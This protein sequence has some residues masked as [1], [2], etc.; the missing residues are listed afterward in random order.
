M[1]EIIIGFLN[2]N[3]HFAV[4]FTLIS[5]SRT[6]FKPA[7]SLIQLYV[8]ATPT[9]K[10]NEVWNKIKEKKSFKAAA[11]AIDYFLSIKLP[12]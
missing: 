4:L 10:D 1:T 6:V 12:K 3:P 2:T 8:D 5:V 11:Y 9:K 7:C